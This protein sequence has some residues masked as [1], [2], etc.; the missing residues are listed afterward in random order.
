M[1]GNVVSL[2]S[3]GLADTVTVSSGNS[4]RCR[5]RV[6]RLAVGMAPHGWRHMHEPDAASVADIE[7]QRL[8]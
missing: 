1:Q 4:A 8:H 3:E 2:T 5:P 7:A 6:E